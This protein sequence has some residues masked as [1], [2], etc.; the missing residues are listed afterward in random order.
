M[1]RWITVPEDSTLVQQAQLKLILL[2]WEGYVNTGP[3]VQHHDMH[4]QLL[5]LSQISL[6]DRL[7]L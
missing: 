1:R 3:V 2:L 7:S 6:T 4:Q 5:P